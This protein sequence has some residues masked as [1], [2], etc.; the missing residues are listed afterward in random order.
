MANLV[1]RSPF[2]ELMAS[3]PRSLLGRDLFSWLRPEG[4]LVE[5]WNPRCDIVEGDGAL[6]LHAELPGVAPED[7]DV[8][9]SGSELIIRGEKRAEKKEE[10]KGRTYSERF[11]G[12]FQRAVA[13]PEGVDPDK[14]EASLKDG[15][16][17]V[18][19]PLPEPAKPAETRKITVKAG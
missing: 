6:I 12:S 1:R 14:I 15:V 8:S 11:F 19:V 9:V 3:W 13:I 7:I 17:E 16:L 18:R 4:G 5:E 2:D 10:A